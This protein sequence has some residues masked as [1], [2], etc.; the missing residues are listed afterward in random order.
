MRRGLLV[1]WTFVAILSAPASAVAVGPGAISGTVSPAAIA[2][3]VEVCVVEPRPSELCTAPDATGAYRLT[4]VPVG[5]L[6]VEFLPSHRSG[7]LVQY[8]D[9]KSLLREATVLGMPPPPN[10]E[11][12]G[13]DAELEPGSEIEGTVTAAPGGTP[14]GGVEVCVQEAGTGVPV[15]CAES[16]ESGK[17]AVTGLASGVYKIGF[18][19]R[20]RAAEYAPQFFDETE[21]FGGATAIT[22]PPGS[23]VIGIDAELTKGARI[24]GMVASASDG[25]ALPGI[26]VCL[27]GV[28]AVQPS[29]CAFTEPTGAY[30]MI[31][32]PTGQYQVGFSPDAAEMG[33]GAIL[34][35]GDGYLPQYYFGAANRL[36]SQTLSLSSGQ[37]LAAINARLSAVASMPPILPPASALTAPAAA[38]QFV[39][40]PIRQP[41]H[42]K[43]SCS[44]SRQK[45]G[46]KGKAK[47]VKNRGRRTRRHRRR[48]R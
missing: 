19:G 32:I 46:A 1:L 15:G 48:R 5:P 18:W 27:F 34:M 20:G 43:K 3:E 33:G 7:Y 35:G 8:Y 29:Q 17:Y 37:V 44:G 38:V 14:L 12:K 2:P 47:C 31:G 6:R 23:D 39:G 13:I 24:E 9:F 41:R 30:A 26:P 11:L 28:A 45:G 16:A 25:S 10:S 42:K 21:S 40:E 36:E 22:V 4:G